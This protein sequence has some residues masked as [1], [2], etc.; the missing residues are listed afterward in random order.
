MNVSVIPEEGPRI[1]GT[2]SRYSTG[3]TVTANCTAGPSMPPVQLSWHINGEKVKDSYVK[4]FL[5]MN[6]SEE[7][8][9]STLQLSFKIKPNHFKKG[10]MKMKVI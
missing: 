5:S 9:V 4:H 6:E 1:T 8:E 2:K 7:L 10:D 3:E